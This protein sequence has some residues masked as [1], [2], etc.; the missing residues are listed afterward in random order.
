MKK[1][2]KEAKRTTFGLILAFA[3]MLGA[4]T[5]DFSDASL[6]ANN[7]CE[8]V[9]LWEFDSSIGIDPYER[10]GHPNYKNINCN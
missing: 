7:Y 3:G 9:N 2:N 6:Q 1:M 10:S 4:A 8:M 5:L